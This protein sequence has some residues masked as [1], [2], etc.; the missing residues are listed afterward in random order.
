M[1]SFVPYL[2]LLVI[3]CL[4]LDAYC[5]RPE[6]GMR[7]QIHTLADTNNERSFQA[8]QNSVNFSRYFLIIQWCVCFGLILYTRINAGFLESLLHPD[9]N[10][11]CQVLLCMSIPAAWLLLQWFLY[12][13]WAFLF[14]EM[15]RALILTRIYRAVHMLAAPVALLVLMM[16]MTEI[17]SPSNSWILLL[18]TFI[19]AQIVFILGGIKI[20][21]SG[22]GTMCFIFLYLCAF[23][24]APILLL[25][26]KLG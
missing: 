5:W 20:F 24:I 14:R 23:K 8:E 17:L 7:R 1:L 6:G 19:I 12:S 3:L 21:W 16:E 11:V 10:V 22:I 25:L 9:W 15:G 4:A 18:L 2:V 26:A 13:W